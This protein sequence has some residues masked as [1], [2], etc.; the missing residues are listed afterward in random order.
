MAQFDE[1]VQSALTL[2]AHAADE[3]ASPIGT[4]FNLALTNAL[5]RVLQGEQD[6]APSLQRAQSEVEDAVQDLE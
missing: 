3:P 2:Q 6:A 4:Q 5:N 1:A